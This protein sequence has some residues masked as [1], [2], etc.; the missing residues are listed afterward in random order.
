[1]SKFCLKYHGGQTNL[2]WIS[3][4]APESL[5]CKSLNYEEMLSVILQ[6]SVHS[7]MFISV[8]LPLSQSKD[9]AP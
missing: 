1:M 8:F 2:I 7:H 3:Q 4:L 6:R 5:M 9:E